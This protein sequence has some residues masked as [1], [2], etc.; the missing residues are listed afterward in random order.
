MSSE[1]DATLKIE[2]ILSLFCFHKKKTKTGAWKRKKTVSAALVSP[3]SSL[4]AALIRQPI[5]K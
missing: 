3:R 4:R 2:V 5:R 1:Q